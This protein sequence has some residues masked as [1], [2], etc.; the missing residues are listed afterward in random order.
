M[1]PAHAAGAA[2]VV[3]LAA[4]P[5]P[6]GQWGQLLLRLYE[7]APVARVPAGAPEVVLSPSGPAEEGPV[8]QCHC[9]ALGSLDLENGF[10]LGVLVGLA[11]CPALEVARLFRLWWAGWLARAERALRQ[12]SARTLSGVGA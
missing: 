6:L 12:P 3:A 11:L 4:A 9:E 5:P 7:Q 10:F 2:A 1:R 8:C